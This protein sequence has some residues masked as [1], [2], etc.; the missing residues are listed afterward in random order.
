[1]KRDNERTSIRIS[2]TK[3][4]PLFTEA[5]ERQSK[6]TVPHGHLLNYSLRQRWERGV[7]QSQVS[8]SLK[9]D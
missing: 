4:A 1:M 7:L 8:P 5:A 2:T 3:F 9:L 6:R